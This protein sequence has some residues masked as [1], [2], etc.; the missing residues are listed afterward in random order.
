VH[1]LLAQIYLDVYYFIEMLITGCAHVLYSQGPYGFHCDFADQSTK[2]GTL[3][4]YDVLSNFRRGDI[5]IQPG[6][7]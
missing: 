4:P 1:A 3:S 6:I 7:P 5:W 2:L